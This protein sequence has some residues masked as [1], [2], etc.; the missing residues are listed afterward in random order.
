MVGVETAKLENWPQT[1]RK[2]AEFKFGG[3]ASLCITP[4]YKHLMCVY[5]AALPSFC[6]RYLNKAMS[7]QIYKK[8]NWQRASTVLAIFNPPILFSPRGA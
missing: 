6:L 5:R 8:Y 4:S 3:G 7:S 2:L 1:E